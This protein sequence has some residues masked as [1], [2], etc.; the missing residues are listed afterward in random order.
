MITGTA[1]QVPF[2]PMTD[3]VFTR[4]GVCAQQVNAGENHARR[5]K[6]AL[7]SVVVPEGL[8]HWMIFPVGQALDRRDVAAVGLDGQ[9]SA[10]FDRLTIQ[11]DRART[12]E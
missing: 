6:A 5:T 11:Q 10:G 3:L 9:H 4:L 1:A 7:Q 8:L 2:Q 12:I